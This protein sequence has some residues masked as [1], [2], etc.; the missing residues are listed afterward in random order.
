MDNIYSIVAELQER[1][2]KHVKDKE[3]MVALFRSFEKE[4]AAMSQKVVRENSL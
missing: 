2:M 4:V 1:M 3:D